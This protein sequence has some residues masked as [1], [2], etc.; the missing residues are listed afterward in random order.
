MLNKK[1]INLK[2]YFNKIDVKF[3][4]ILNFHFIII[5]TFKLFKIVNNF[6]D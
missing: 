6:W 5:H 2:Y 1:S 4:F 3:M